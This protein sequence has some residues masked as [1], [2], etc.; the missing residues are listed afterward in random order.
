MEKLRW[1]KVPTDIKTRVLHQTGLNVA[2]PP[3]LPIN[4]DC[5]TEFGKTWY[6]P[7]TYKIEWWG[8]G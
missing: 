2:L 8:G 5:G 1:D 3:A 4:I 7:A 6:Y